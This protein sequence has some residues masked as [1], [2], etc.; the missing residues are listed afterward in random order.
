LELGVAVE[1]I[2]LQDRDVDA[3]ACWGPKHGPAV[4]ANVSGRRACDVAGR[5]ATLCHEIAHLLIDRARRLPLAEIQGAMHH[6]WVESRANAFAAEFLVPKATA[7]EA[8]AAC[9]TPEATQRALNSV[10]K[11]YG[12]SRELIA[13]QALNSSVALNA[14]ARRVL[15]QSVPP[16]RRWRFFSA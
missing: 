14:T 6:S 10:A 9:N 2:D 12:A 3:I 4:F 8:F 15:A 5:R 13:W 11:K 7:G 1:N 16:D